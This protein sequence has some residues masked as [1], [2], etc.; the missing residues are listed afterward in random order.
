MNPV[1][2]QPPP[3]EFQQL[4]DQAMRVVQQNNAK[5]IFDYEEKV[6]QNA[7]YTSKGLPV[8]AGYEA[9]PPVL[10]ALDTDKYI[11]LYVQDEQAVKDS[12]PDGKTDHAYDNLSD[13]YSL[14]TYQPPVAEKPAEIPQPK[15]PL[16]IML[17][18][19]VFARAIGDKH[20]VGFVFPFLGDKYVLTNYGHRTLTGA[21]IIVYVRQ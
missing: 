13:A 21:E 17:D 15:N 8:P 11:A 18:E 6:R 9:I 2:T 10:T 14:F 4:A 3:V 1:P 12:G 19:G 16:G 5:K 20:P 7:D